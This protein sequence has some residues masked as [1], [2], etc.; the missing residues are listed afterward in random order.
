MQLNPPM[1]K[2]VHWNK[3][4]K[5]IGVVGVAP[6]ATAYFYQKLIQLTPVKKEWEHV[7]VII[8]SNPKIP[9][10][11]R[12]LELG[13]T[14]PSPFIQQTIAKLH[15]MGASIIAVPCNTAHI[16]YEEYTK[17]LLE[18]NIVNMIEETVNS[19]V[20]SI[21]HIPQRAAVFGSVMTHA[22]RLYHDI[23]E[24]RGGNI[25]NTSAH[26]SHISEIIDEVKQGKSLNILR[27]KFLNILSLYSDA[28][29]YILGCT[30]LSLLAE[31]SFNRIP[32]I[33]SNTALAK[34]CLMLTNNN[35]YNHSKQNQ[36]TEVVL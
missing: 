3:E 35:A 29:V 21:R 8:D 28:D 34:A 4:E 2:T 9:S 11:G 32:I 22:H 24:N 20:E 12:Y 33:D 25:L 7:R 5:V 17:N 26:Q 10:R 16:L 27:T 13:E 19:A 30:E 18:M 15:E 1:N 36:I 6:A 31:G 14:N 23:L